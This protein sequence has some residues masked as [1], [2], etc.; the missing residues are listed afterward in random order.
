MKICPKCGMQLED[1]AAFCNNCGAGLPPS[2][3]QYNAS[4]TDTQYEA[5]QQG[6]V[7]SQPTVPRGVE[8]LRRV[9]T[10]P[11]ALVAI[12]AF[13]ASMFFAVIS[14]V[15]GVS[16]SIEYLNGV[17]G[18][19]EDLTDEMGITQ[20]V[21]DYINNMHS[22]GILSALISN[23]PAILTAA[24]LWMIFANCMNRR[25]SYAK[26]GGF[27]LIKVIQVI[28]LV[29]F[30]IGL[31][32]AVLLAVLLFA[33]LSGAGASLAD[34]FAELDLD[35]EATKSMIGIVG[36]I[37]FV[38]IAVVAAL[39]ISFY[40]CAIKTINT[41]RTTAATGV[42]SDR[43]SSYLAVLSCII[44]GFTAVTAFSYDVLG[45]IANVCS[46]VAYIA[47]GCFIFQYK[48]AMRNAELESQRVGANN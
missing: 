19:L 24:G 14:A 20:Q 4:Q 25:S 17:V 26:T 27:T 1:N 47:F 39:V 7:Y 22:T 35:I 12:I 40:V 6:G 42:I 11:V 38:L 46:A 15:T 28:T 32:L 13:T 48:N 36:V 34:L 8:V 23:L 16:G 2:D 18:D 33:V 21:Y 41:M 5:P 44:G 37:L 10:S 29:F 31:A 45:S 30:C 9:C 43:V 3:A